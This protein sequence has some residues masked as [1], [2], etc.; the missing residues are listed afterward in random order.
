MILWCESDGFGSHAN[1]FVKIR[2]H[3][4]SSVS[5]EVTM[6]DFKHLIRQFWVAILKL[7]QD[8]LFSRDVLTICHDN[9]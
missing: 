1:S 4:D 5:N 8:G 2:H 7:I 3:L 9:I 6:S